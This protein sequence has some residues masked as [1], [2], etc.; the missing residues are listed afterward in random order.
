MPRPS[1]LTLQLQD[2]KKR[3]PSSSPQAA[4]G[5]VKE[6]ASLGVGA[7]YLLLLKRLWLKVAC[8]AKIQT[9]KQTPPVPINDLLE[10]W[11]QD[12]EQ[13]RKECISYK[14]YC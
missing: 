3:D 11:K 14:D 10:I 6:S 7:P 4:I 8:K 2:A 1:L 12:R 13:Q 5:D 9:R